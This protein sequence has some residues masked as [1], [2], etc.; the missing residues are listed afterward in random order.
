VL[1]HL[2]YDVWDAWQ[3]WDAEQHAATEPASVRLTR[4]DVNYETALM[5]VFRDM[6]DK[7][8]EEFTL[9]YL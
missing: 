6:G 5:A 7:M 1:R 2:G 9:V 8:P 3:P 4:K